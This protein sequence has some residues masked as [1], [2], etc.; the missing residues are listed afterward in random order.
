ML[1][2]YLAMYV[3]SDNE[4]EVQ[5]TVVNRLGKALLVGGVVTL[6]FVVLFGIAGIV[7]GG[8]ARQV[9]S[10]I[11]WVGLFIGVILAF[12][13]AWLIGGG[14]IYSAIAQQASTKMGDPGRV[15]VK[16]YFLFGLSYGTASLSCTL[17]PFLAVLG[18]G[19]ATNTLVDSVVSFV[20]F[21]LGMGSVIIVLT[22][23]MAIFKGAMVGV[24][25]KILPYTQPIS[26]V[27]MILAG[28]Y[29]VFYWL[30][31]GGLL[32]QLT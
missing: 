30:T 16:G 13:G 4:T 2:A 5:P 6:G 26:A 15:N 27:F 17:P 31:A 18:I 14:K 3:G 23:A 29:I 9:V 7:I 10:I 24:L 19:I 32:D 28:S 8:G 1:P 22:I 25:R 12:V 20:L 21:G 11:P